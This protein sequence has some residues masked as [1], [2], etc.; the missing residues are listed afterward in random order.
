[1]NNVH[2]V[3]ILG[4]L[5]LAAAVAVSAAS[6]D[7]WSASTAKE[8]MLG[9]FDGTALDQ[10]GHLTLAPHL[11][12]LWGPES[13]I[14]WDL[15]P[16]PKGTVFA[17]LSGPGR[18]LAVDREGQVAL[19]YEAD[20]DSLITALAP[21]GK[22][23]VYAGLSPEG[24]VVHLTGPGEAASLAESGSTFVW[25]LAVDR[26]GTVWIGSGVPGKI[27]R[28][29]RGGAL[30]TLHETGEDPVR[31]IL[32]TAHGAI[33]GTGG[34][35]RVIRVSDDGSRYVLFDAAEAEIVGLA[36]EDDGTVWALA[37]SGLK[38]P[39]NA[40]QPA[41]KADAYVKVTADAPAP[42]GDP[43]NSA[44]KP[45]AKT[46]PQRPGRTFRG[47][48]GA[49]LYRIRDTRVDTVWSSPSVIPFDLVRAP[50][51]SLL[52]STGDNGHVWR[53][54]P[55]GKAALMIPVAS[56]QAS[57]MAQGDDGTLWIGGT[58]DARIER[59]DMRLREQGVYLSLPI[60]AGDRAAWGRVV[61]DATVPEGCSIDV[62][63]RAGNTTEPDPTWS[64]WVP[65]DPQGQI[66]ARRVPSSR[67]LQLKLSLSSAGAATGPS[68]SAMWLS[69]QSRNRAPRVSGINVEAPGVVILAIPKPNNASL[70]P[71]VAD[72]PVTRGAVSRVFRGAARVPTRRGYEAGVR[73]FT[74]T[75]ADPDGD[76]LRYRIDVRLER[77]TFW[78]PLAAQLTAPY[79]SW[80][81]RATPDGRYRVRL[82]ASDAMDNAEGE[83]LTHTETSR[84][85][86][87]DNSRPSVGQWSVESRGNARLVE[88]TA[89]DPGGAV[90]AV[91]IA[92]G[93]GDWRPL[94]PEDGV[95]DSETERFR[96]DLGREAAEL[97]STVRVRVIDAAGN[98]GGEMRR[99][100][101][102]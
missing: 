67:L 39:V 68:V 75:A 45:P 51:R 64:D 92:V 6:I 53:I 87:V 21:D 93:D 15:A 66:D 33:A 88:F 95:A 97:P 36:Y 82:T 69:Y 3:L 41:V 49:R 32:P 62:A 26:R 2:R 43:K 35:G 1:M 8:F 14:V 85:F 98:L 63:V 10:E 60:D 55:D 70:G 17:A 90:A 23:G 40:G 34:R 100:D 65:V 94:Y 18:V 7:R 72:D 5:G 86:V 38:Q 81:A 42:N 73:T 25:A 71:L 80:D 20:G 54:D 96:V 56:N 22:G 44:D 74:W 4:W 30:E 50:D 16:G 59:L 84:V 102:P 89:I 47:T 9:R 48:S 12:H 77:D 11:T 46:Q 27:Q 101:R 29:R 79:F 31:S 76:R 37:A 83:G 24:R 57:A 52:V 91:E 78:F 61:W 28:L 19:W 99:I 58:S 13:G